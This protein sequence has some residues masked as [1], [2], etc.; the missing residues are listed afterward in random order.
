EGEEVAEVDSVVDAA[1]A[2]LVDSG[3]RRPT[4]VDIATGNEDFSTLVS[5]LAQAGL[6][7]AV[8]GT[9]PLT[10]FAPANMAFESFV[11]EFG[12][13]F[14]DGS[15]VIDNE[16]LTSVLLF[17]VS[18][19][20]VD[21]GQVISSTSLDTVQGEPLSV[22]ITGDGIVLDERAQLVAIDLRARN[23]IVH[24]IDT[25]LTP[26]ALDNVPS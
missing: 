14:E 1:I 22:A 3:A 19:G 20:N 21:S 18:P 17:H 8:S 13:E 23:G 24:V 10:V 25:V 5:L 15:L 7:G 4:L 11:A 2:D 16:L 6:L 9:D 26:S 12:L